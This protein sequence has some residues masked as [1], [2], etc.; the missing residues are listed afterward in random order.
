MY[1]IIEISGKQYKTAEGSTL[2]IPLQKGDVGSK[3]YF[4]KILVV[5]DLNT[6]QFGS[7][8]IKNAKVTAKITSHGKEKK[9]L[10]Y[11]KKRRKGYQRK[12]GHQQRFTEVKIEKI[13]FKASSK[14]EAVLQK[15]EE[16]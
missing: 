1:A 11:K 8:N 14:S 7:P 12:N 15:E 2:R 9:I 4:D 10:V 5:S 13:Q 16:E 6:Q 3:L